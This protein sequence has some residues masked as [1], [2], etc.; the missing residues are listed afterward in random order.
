[1][2]QAVKLLF[3]IF[4][5]I[6]FF[7][8][9]IVFYFIALII[10]L[11]T[12]PFD[13]QRKITHLFIQFWG[14]VYILSIPTWRFKIEGRENLDKHKSYVIVA[15][16]QSQLDIISSSLLFIPFKWISKSEVFKVPIV[17]WAMKLC[18]Y[19]ELKRGDRKSVIHMIRDA[20]KSIKNGN[21]IFIFP[22][23]TRSDDGKLKQFKSGAFIIAKRTKAP[24]L[25]IVMKGTRDILPKGT[26]IFN[27]KGFIHYKIL[28]EIPYEEYKDLETDEI[29]NKVRDIIAKELNNL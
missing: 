12:T 28:P 25:P 15:N 4:F 19:I 27:P 6:Y 21:S 24:I 5:F 17:G 11:V 23:G 10:W 20:E 14:A 8:I 26:L 29:A 9:G 13:K 16:H 3:T 18:K 22:E 7:S 1:M 2:K